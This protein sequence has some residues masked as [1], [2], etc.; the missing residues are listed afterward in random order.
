MWREREGVRVGKV[1]EGEE[2]ECGGRGG[3]VCGVRREGQVW[4]GRGRSV[5]MEEGVVCEGVTVHRDANKPTFMSELAK[6]LQ[7]QLQKDVSGGVVVKWVLSEL[8]LPLT[9]S[10]C[11]CKCGT[12][13]HTLICISVSSV[14]IGVS[15]TDADIHSVHSATRHVLRMA[16][17]SPVCGENVREV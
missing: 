13:Q 5:S 6:Y 1:G 15:S 4:E 16:E 11:T 7:H 14:C 17:Y 12:L 3:T 2:C 9:Y 10:L 8:I